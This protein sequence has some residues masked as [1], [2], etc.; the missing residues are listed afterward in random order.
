V[1]RTSWL[2][3]LGPTIPSDPVSATDRMRN[4]LK[5]GR[6]MTGTALGALVGR[7]ASEVRALMHNDITKGKVHYEGGVY[8]L[9]PELD[10]TQQRRIQEAV[11][12]LR[13]HG[14]TVTKEEL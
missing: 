8:S 6:P 3:G 4:A 7:G 11:N 10:A 2:H 9:P 14:Y 13:C 12:L 1:I 5:A